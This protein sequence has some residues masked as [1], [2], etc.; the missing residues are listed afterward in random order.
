MPLL[1]CKSVVRSSSILKLELVIVFVIFC[2]SHGALALDNL[3]PHANVR[4]SHAGILLQVKCLVNTVVH[5]MERICFVI[6]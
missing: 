2:F 3:G 4:L 1:I 5:S 6:V